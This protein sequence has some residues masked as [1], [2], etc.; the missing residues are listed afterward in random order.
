MMSLFPLGDNPDCALAGRHKP[1]IATFRQEP[2]KCI[3]AE[4]F[5]TNA[6]LKP[7]IKKDWRTEALLPL[8]RIDGSN[9][10]AGCTAPAP[11]AKSKDRH[12]VSRNLLFRHRLRPIVPLLM[13]VPRPTLH[14]Q[15]N[16][17][18]GKPRKSGRMRTG[19][20]AQ[21]PR[22]RLVWLLPTSPPTASCKASVYTLGLKNFSKG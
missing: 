4:A 17:T 5:C 21:R 8:R 1:L 19:A 16:E 12:H 2:L 14:L 6:A 9:Q 18:M 15:S 20:S 22:R 13:G 10:F 3:I 11:I 7:N